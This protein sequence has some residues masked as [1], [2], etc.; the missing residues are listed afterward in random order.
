M[1]RFFDP[2]YIYLAQSDTTVG[3]LSQ[4][5]TALAAT[6]KRD[7]AQPFLS[8]IDSFRILTAKCR[9]PNLHKNRVRRSKKTTYIFPNGYACRVV[10]EG[11]HQDFLKKFTWLYSSSANLTGKSF[12]DT[13]AKKKADIIVLD[14]RGFHEDSPSKILRLGKKTQRKIR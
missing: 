1:Y 11:M 12:D 9:V 5:P 2:K 4:A 3:F 6:K 7:P 14:R 8:C 10:K 13:Y